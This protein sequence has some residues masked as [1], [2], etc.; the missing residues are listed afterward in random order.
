[1]I[2]SLARTCAPAALALLLAACAPAYLSPLERDHPLVGR[3]WDTRSA[4]FVSPEALLGRAISARVVLLGEIHDN[5]DHHRLQ[6]EV[7]AAM[8][9]AGRAPA[10]A[11]EQFDLGHQA[12]LDSAQA[13]GIRDPERIADAGGLDRKGWNWPLYRPLVA[14]ALSA[15]LRVVAANVSRE[16]ARALAKSGKPAEGLQPAEP[17]LRASLEQDI[18]DG[19]CGYRPPPPVLAGMVEA[20][21]A[22]DAQMAAALVRSGTPGAVLIAGAG[23]TRRDRGVPAYLPAAIREATLAIAFLEV[24]PEQQQ[25]LPE[26]AG[27]Y[28]LIWFTPRADRPDPCKGFRMP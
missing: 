2:A 14:R 13:Q 18:V 7:L 8:L 22:R 26:Y 11:M 28:D 6:E 9:K 4:S 3:V 12:A 19:H 16:E 24:D 20:Q 27:Q 10:L 5:V 23:H 1:L 17:G 21:R 15:D 25:P